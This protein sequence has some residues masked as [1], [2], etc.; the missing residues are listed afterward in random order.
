MIRVPGR[1]ID[2]IA[3]PRTSRN[4][5]SH[6]LSSPQGMG[7][8]FSSK[9]R[10]RMKISLLG[11]VLISML[12]LG[13]VVALVPL[14]QM[15]AGYDREAS[16]FVVINQLLGGTAT[17]RQLV[18]ILGSLIVATFVVKA[19]ATIS[20]RR[21][22]IGFVADEE[23]E[24]ASRLLDGYLNAPY[25]MHLKRHSSDLLRVLGE[26]AS[27][28]YTATI[29][30]GLGLLTD[31]TTVFFLACA[32][33]I[34]APVPAVIA[35][36]F[37]G[38]AGWLIQRFV[39]PRI[40][41]SGA[42]MV[43]SAGDAVRA[44]L[45]ALGGVKEIKLR[46]NSSEYA[47]RYAIFRQQLAV[48]RKTQGIMMEL[49]R[50]A[51]ELVF[52]FGVA[53]VAGVSFF[54][55]SPERAV[56]TLGLFV[57]VGVRLMPTV[58]R[59]ISNI[60]LMRYG[61]GGLELVLAEMRGLERETTESSRTRIDVSRGSLVIDNVSFRYE[62]APYDV[63]SGASFEIPW[64]MTTALVGASGAG[65][66]TL[67]DLI[68]GLHRPRSGRILVGS[69]DVFKNL[70]S[71]QEQLAVVPQDV[72]LLDDTLRA[73]IA[74]SV[75][76]AEIDDERVEEA[77]GRAELSQLVASLP[78]GLETQVG[79]RGVRISGGQ[80]QRI[81]IARALYRRPSLLVMDEA[82]SAL[83]NDTEQRFTSTIRSLHG[84]M[85]II[86]VAHRLSTVR[87]CDQLVFISHGVVQSVGTFDEVRAANSEFAQL[88]SLGGLDR[89]TPSRTDEV[90]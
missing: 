78:N 48:A 81:G 46:G 19:V 10:R 70:S 47:A 31:I 8:L 87:N 63:V 36:V 21:W 90:R 71:Y 84:T 7:L 72:F 30:G 34:F 6:L 56:S 65:K 22:Q 79:E 86:V 4:R 12:D 40:V 1:M 15:V 41:A 20:F 23:A 49:P 5:R 66:S 24:A 57:V 27:Q 80:K 60:N 68:L 25:A 69:E 26:G 11:C 62:D 39:K 45:E 2:P 3:V 61:W 53:L 42:Q 51:I 85:T 37:F 89:P 50:H 17:D 64:G 88:V 59:M 58:S 35:L 9:A 77:V 52:V 28:T 54:V 38:V 13:G 43:Q 44:S 14:L 33:L 18:S 29:S 55:Y 73:N 67:V 74:F 76:G 82:T 75:S 16:A 32:L 83:D